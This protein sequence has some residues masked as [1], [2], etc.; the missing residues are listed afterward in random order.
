LPYLEYAGFYRHDYQS[1]KDEMSRNFTP[2]Y[3]STSDGSDLTLCRILETTSKFNAGYNKFYH[4][5]SAA[6][7]N[8]TLV[9]TGQSV[10]GMLSVFH[11]G[12]GNSN[13][14]VKIYNTAGVPTASD[15][16]I[17]T[18]CIHPGDSFYTAIPNGLFCSDGL[19][20]RFTANYADNDN[21]AISANEL[22]INIAYV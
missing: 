11:I 3:S 8:A 18:L 15:T 2:V 19:G 10:V 4:N 7:T 21:T 9:Q 17:L 14:F 13:R 1:G 12:N 22:V 6:S 20:F 16:P 5:I